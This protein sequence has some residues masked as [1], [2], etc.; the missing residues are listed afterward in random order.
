MFISLKILKKGNQIAFLYKKAGS[1]LNYSF[2]NPEKNYLKLYGKVPFPVLQRASFTIEAALL[3]PILI[4]GIVTLVSVMDFFRMESMIIGSLQESAETLGM[5]GAVEDYPLKGTLIAAVQ[6]NVPEEVQKKGVLSL[7][8][9]RTYQDVIEL[10]AVYRYQLPFVPLPLRAV[11]RVRVYCWRGNDHMQQAAKNSGSEEMVYV[12]DNESVYH[13]SADCSHV[14]LKIRVVP[15]QMLG[16]LRN[17]YQ[18]RYR[19]CAFCKNRDEECPV[20]YI[21][22]AGDR[23]HKNAGCSGL[24]RTVRMVKKSEVSGLPRCSRCSKDT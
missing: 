11:N 22:E 15:Q 9:S 16:E 1:L 14:H 3:L 8:G 13:V 5:Y 12:T 17:A 10:E 20:V 18:A 21:S 7:A 4:F 19:E 6:R 24:K 23:F 2:S